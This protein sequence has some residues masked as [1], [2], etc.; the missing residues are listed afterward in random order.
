M[1]DRIHWF[2]GLVDLLNAIGLLFAGGGGLAHDVGHAAHAHHDFI[3]GGAG[4][5]DVLYAFRDIAHRGFNQALDLFG[6]LGRALGQV[7]HLAGHHRKATALL[8][9]AGGFYGRIQSPNVG[10]EGNAVNHANDVGNLAR[11]GIDRLH[12]LHH[13][14]DHLAP[15]HGH[16]RG[17]VR[18]LVGQLAMLKVLPRGGGQLVHGG[19][20][21]FQLGGLLFGARGQIGI[22]H[23]NL[24][25][26]R[27]NGLAAVLHLT[28]DVAQAGV[29]GRQGG[30]QLGRF[31]LALHRDGLA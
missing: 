20:C 27:G 8:A 30:E 15:A 26:G 13:L 4:G 11:G 10:L 23:G 2:D 31:I 28:D 22:A 12:G 5:F 19:G 7:A 21:F 25:R 29:H 1:R 17:L 9:S 6:R 24:C 3:H 16:R 18:D 14:R